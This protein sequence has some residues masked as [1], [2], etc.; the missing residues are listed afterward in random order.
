MPIKNIKVLKSKINKH[1][2]YDTIYNKAL[3][4][5]Y[6]DNLNLDELKNEWRI[7]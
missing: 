3:T 1:N 4:L 2:T 6:E 5:N 7:L